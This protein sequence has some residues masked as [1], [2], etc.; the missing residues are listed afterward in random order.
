[1]FGWSVEL[2]S[3]ARNK[4]S[5]LYQLTPGLGFSFTYCLPTSTSFGYLTIGSYNPGQYSF[6]PMASS[7]L[8]VSLYFVSLIGISVVGSSLVISSSK[9]SCLPMIIDYSM[10]MSD[11]MTSDERVH[12]TEHCHAHGHERDATCGGVLH[13]RHVLPGPDVLAARAS[14]DHGIRRRRNAAACD[15]KHAH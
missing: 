7:S 14:G 8:D 6:T 12:G 4:L 9:Y 10:V 5:L 13:P 3:L 1:L 2:I 11:H 15:A